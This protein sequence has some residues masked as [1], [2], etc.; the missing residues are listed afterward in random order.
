MTLNANSGVDKADVKLGGDGRFL[1]LYVARFSVYT[2]Y[3]RLLALAG[4]EE[5]KDP[6]IK[7]SWKT[8]PV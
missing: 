2:G 6:S 4:V 1:E 7:I 5:S 3:N 8:T